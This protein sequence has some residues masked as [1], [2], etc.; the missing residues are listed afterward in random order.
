MFN[1]ILNLCRKTP[2]SSGRLYDVLALRD[3]SAVAARAKRRILDDT[4]MN[5]S[6][7]MG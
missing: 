2:S 5:L 1:G 3:E 4:R 6:T 7:E